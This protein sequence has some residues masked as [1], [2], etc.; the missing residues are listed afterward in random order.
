MLSYRVFRILCIS[1]A[2]LLVM[3]FLIISSHPYSFMHTVYIYLAGSQGQTCSH[4]CFLYFFPYISLTC[5]GAHFPLNKVA[6]PH[7]AK[8]NKNQNSYQSALLVLLLY[9][10][11]A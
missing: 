3:I 4:L 1:Y 9:H 7:L 6:T 10:L 11:L 8:N 5:M 2:P